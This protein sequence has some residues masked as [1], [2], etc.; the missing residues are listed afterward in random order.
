MFNL[1]KGVVHGIVSKMI[2]NEELYA[3]VDQVLEL[4]ILHRIE[5]TRLQFLA[6]QYT[7]K[8][9]N[10]V[11]SNEK[12]FEIKAQGFFGKDDKQPILKKSKYSQYSSNSNTSNSSNSSSSQNQ[13]KKSSFPF[14]QSKK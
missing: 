7:D 3:S 4:I 11:E 12:L 9:T 10:L 6:L 8:A 2:V 13:H 14:S 1:E 5:P